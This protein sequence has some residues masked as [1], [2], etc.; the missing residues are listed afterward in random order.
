MSDLIEAFGTLPAIHATLLT[1]LL[2]VAI[3]GIVSLFRDQEIT[4][5]SPQDDNEKTKGE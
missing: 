1:G 4:I 3:W 2:G 5:I